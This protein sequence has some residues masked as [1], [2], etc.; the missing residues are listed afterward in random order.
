MPNIERILIVGAG[1]AGLALAAALR[2]RA[3]SAVVVERAPAS[4]AGGAGLYVVGAGTRA[5]R[6]LGVAESALRESR[7]IHAEA[8]F[9]HRGT[10]LA[11]IDVARFWSG[12]GPCIG[13]A[14]T[15]LHR[16]LAEMAA[17]EVRFGTDVR[18]LD[19]GTDEVMV[20]F[21][22]G[23]V[24]GFDLVVGADGVHSAVRGFAGG[25][26]Q[27][28]YRGQIGW[29]FI[30]ACPGRIDAWTVFLGA[31]RA[32]LF[33]PIGGGRAYCYADKLSA[34]L[35]DTWRD[36]RLEQ[37]RGLFEDFAEPVHEA[38]LHVESSDAIHCSPIEEVSHQPVGRGRIVL[39]GDA[40]HAM[41]PNMACGVAI[42]L[43]DALVLAELVRRGDERERIA[44]AFS[45][46]RAPRIEQLRLQTDQRDR[47]RGLPA[48][49]RDLSPRLFASRIYRRNYQSVLMPA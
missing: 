8:F 41:S 36:A 21:S 28:R 38:L 46:R 13:V 10:R 2:Q 37:L 4:A 34:N 5:L 1:I 27:P 32:F 15:V 3:M 29:R 20:R 16:A 22:D 49:L 35:P 45:R 48:P 47:M 12:C 33:V 42:A 23:T 43:E 6:A 30:A 9:S 19:E 14:R 11:E 40:A 17:V 31:G 18:S 26:L 44:D 7:Q 39:I 25:T 24:A